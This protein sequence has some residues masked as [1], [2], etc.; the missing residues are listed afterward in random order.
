M[1]IGAGALVLEPW[2]LLKRNPPLAE[3]VWSPFEGAR[4]TNNDPFGNWTIAKMRRRN[5][6]LNREALNTLAIVPKD[7]VLEIGYGSGD[8]LAHATRMAKDGF[9]AGIDRSLDMLQRGHKRVKKSKAKN[10]TAMR[11]DVSWMPW[12]A[13]SFDKVFCVD[14]ITEWPCTRS[15]LEEAFRV[16]RPGGVLVLAEHITD[17]FTKHKAL[18][19]AHVLASVGFQNLEV[20]IVPDR[21]SEMLLLKAI[22]D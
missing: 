14:G 7:H 10:F 19:L 22:R 18:A 12:S 1:K 4:N 5:R 2:A 8:S 15:G 20:Q 6:T 9:A 21:G 17:Q 3:Q 11:G 13:C 16:L